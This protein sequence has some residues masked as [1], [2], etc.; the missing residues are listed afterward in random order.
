MDL[1]ELK[2][3]KDYLE[4]A[5]AQTLAD[6]CEEFTSEPSAIDFT[7]QHESAKGESKVRLM[8][9]CVTLRFEL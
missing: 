7:V 3:R 2:R 5:M 1:K 6:F 4:E 9:V 8:R